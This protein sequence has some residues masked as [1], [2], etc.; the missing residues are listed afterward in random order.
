[1][2]VPTD[3][4]EANAIKLLREK[5]ERYEKALKYIAGEQR[6]HGFKVRPTFALAI[7][8]AKDALEINHAPQG[9]NE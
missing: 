6:S 1:M 9:T 4:N 5:C 8:A 3:P 2:T 7:L